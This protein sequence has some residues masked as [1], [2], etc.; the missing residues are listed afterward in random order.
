MAISAQKDQTEQEL[1]RVR[2]GKKTIVTYR[3]NI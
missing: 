3:N 1:N 2:K